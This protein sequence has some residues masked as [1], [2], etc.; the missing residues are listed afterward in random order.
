MVNTKSRASSTN[1]L[2]GYSWGKVEA[3]VQDVSITIHCLPRDPPG[4]LYEATID[5]A[6]RRLLRERSYIPDRNRLE[7]LPPKDCDDPAELRPDLR[8]MLS[9]LP[10]DIADRVRTTFDL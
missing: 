4:M 2:L 8:N 9:K 3:F 10:R 1:Y 5:R 6:E 7:F